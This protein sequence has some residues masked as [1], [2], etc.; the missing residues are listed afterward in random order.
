MLKTEKKMN[1]SI[2]SFVIRIM[3]Y[4]ATIIG[5]SVAFFNYYFVKGWRTNMEIAFLISLLVSTFI[6]EF[7][8]RLVIK[9][10][11]SCN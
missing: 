4:V 3:I 11:V 1:N 2:N 10:F 8:S 9:K 6:A 7:I 5:I